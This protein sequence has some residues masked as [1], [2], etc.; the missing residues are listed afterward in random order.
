[1]PLT[2]KSLGGMISVKWTAPE[3]L[4]YRTST[5]QL[6]MCGVMDVS[7]L[8]Y[9]LLVTSHSMMTLIQRS[10]LYV[11]GSPGFLDACDLVLGSNLP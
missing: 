7:S 5:L 11:G 6:M 10:L 2:T 4:H 1:M 3:A 9:G 8:K